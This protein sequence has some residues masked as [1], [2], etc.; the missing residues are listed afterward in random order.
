MKLS[1]IVSY[2][3]AGAVLT[4]PIDVTKNKNS[5]FS[6]G[7]NTAFAEAEG[8]ADRGGVDQGGG[9]NGSGGSGNNAGGGGDVNSNT[10]SGF[11][12]DLANSL[13]GQMAMAAAV[14]QMDVGT[15]MAMGLNP[16]A[17]N[18]D[19]S[20]W[21]S[22]VPAPGVVIVATSFVV[23]FGR[24][25]TPGAPGR[26]MRGD[27]YIGGYNVGYDRNGQMTIDFGPGK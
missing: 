14:G 9:N 3:L 12:F 22:S 6:M 5:H 19:G 1:T 11:G 17:M 27:G 26:V 13:S 8:G 20:V 21:G 4:A 15:A 10:M 16:G 25:G 7:W 18:M 2:V 24:I 23:V